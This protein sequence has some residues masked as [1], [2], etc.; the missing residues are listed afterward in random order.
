MCNIEQIYQ[1]ILDGKRRRFPPN[2]WSD[3]QDNNLARRV[4]KYLIENVLKW[5]EK[6]I[7]S[8]WKEK[9]I[10]KYKLGGLL[11][12]KYNGSPYAM[13]NDVY[14]D[15]FK[16][17][18]FKMTPKNYWTK[19]TA[20]EALKWTIEEK[21][22][23]TDNELLEVYS[24]YWLSNHK[25][26]SPCRIFWKGIPYIMI[27]ELYPNRFKEWEFKKTR[28]NSW[29][30]KK[31]LKALKWVIEEKEQMDNQQIRIKISV[32]W[33][34][35]KGLRTPLERYWNDSPFNFINELY[36]GLFKEWEFQMTPK[37][38]WTKE[39]ALEALKW[40][41]E[42]KE[43]LTKEQLIQVYNRQWIINQGLR[44]PLERYWNNSPYAM[45][46]DTYPRKFKGWELNRV[47]C[48]FW[49]KER[50][51]EALKWTI[52]EKEKLTKEQLIQ[53]YNRQWIINQGLR[54]PLEKFWNSNIHTMLNELYPKQ[55][56]KNIKV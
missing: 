24:C 52:E 50:A 10:I 33:L 54:T 34:A 12:V 13:I 32:L 53:V 9:L 37:N 16:E 15:Y 3:D 14:P 11:S 31:A 47:P 22:K 19:E 5:D 28:S 38:Y 46:N 48:G 27:N 56:V 26:N 43:K 17:W 8:D 35:Q 39:R 42:E 2:T 55:F 23:L 29:T 45:L 1:E 40:T 20:L 51:L 44:T 4:I 36:P 6:K 30:R 25:L 21:E 49:T 41:I 18:V 7:I